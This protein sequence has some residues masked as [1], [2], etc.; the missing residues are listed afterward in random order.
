MYGNNQEKS[1]A[2]CVFED[3]LI[4]VG[5]NKFLKLIQCLVK[6]ELKVEGDGVLVNIVQQTTSLS[7]VRRA[8]LHRAHF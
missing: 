5:T 2:N 4:W 6:V 1:W 3:R 7:L 8:I